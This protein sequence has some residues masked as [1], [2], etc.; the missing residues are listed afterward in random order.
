MTA[1]NRGVAKWS[2]RAFGDRDVKFGHSWRIGVPHLVSYY[3][4][5]ELG[6]SWDRA[7]A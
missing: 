2:S 6:H 5:S 3:S 7:K 1:A 4:I